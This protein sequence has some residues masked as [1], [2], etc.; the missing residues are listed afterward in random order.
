M[1]GVRKLIERDLYVE[2]LAVPVRIDLPQGT[3]VQQIKFSFRDIKPKGT[4]R[5]YI[6]KPSGAEIYNNASTASL[7]ADIP[8][9]VFNTTTQMT[10]EAGQMQ[11]QVRVTDSGD[12]ILNS[13]PITLNI[14]E[15]PVT[16]NAIESEDEFTALDEALAA[17]QPAIDS[18]NET[19]NTVKKAESGRVSAEQTRENN[20]NT[21]KGNENTRQSQ[22]SIRQQNE[23]TRQQWY[24]S[25]KSEL[26]NASFGIGTVNTGPAGSSAQANITGEP[27]KQLLNLTIPRGDKG[28]PGGINVKYVTSLSALSFDQ[29]TIVVHTSN[30]GAVCYGVYLYLV[31]AKFDS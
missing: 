6:K 24:N 23:T 27:F 21:R 12:K 19:N 4:V 18:L 10:A 22:E 26:D 9:A 29:D 3:N 28:D 15:S 14:I 31:N 13:F 7:D 30:S 8:F 1:T 11:G 17:V 16:G 5:I 2:Q 20:E 25:A